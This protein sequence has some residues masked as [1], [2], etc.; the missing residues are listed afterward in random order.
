[1]LRR[2]GLSGRE[3]EMLGIA[4]A[5]ADEQE[6]AAELFLSSHAVHE[7]LGHIQEKLDVSTPAAAVA[8]GSAKAPSR[9][10][11]P[12]GAAELASLRS[13]DAGQAV[14]QRGGE[15]R[16]AGDGGEC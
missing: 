16:W 2:L 5:I 1:M 10:D 14:G 13:S 4:A 6:I 7:R 8:R 9:H 12:G 11:V 15:G 3:T